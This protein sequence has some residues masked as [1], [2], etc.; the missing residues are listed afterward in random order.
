[1][2]PRM[3]RQG[4]EIRAAGKL[5]YKMLA[6]V[7]VALSLIPARR[8]IIGYGAIVAA[9]FLLDGRHR[10]IHQLCALDSLHFLAFLIT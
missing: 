9:V 7:S 5:D 3:N 10:S 4:S 2:N 8:L 1:M 6:P